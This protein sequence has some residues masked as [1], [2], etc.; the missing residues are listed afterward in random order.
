MAEEPT[1]RRSGCRATS[2]RKGGSHEYSTRETVQP[3]EVPGGVDTRRDRRAPW[4]APQFIAETLLAGEGFTEVHYIELPRSKLR[5]I[6]TPQTL[7]LKTS[8]Q[9][10]AKQASG[11]QT[12]RD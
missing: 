11:N 6:K 8:G 5:G 2:I 10:Q 1:G 3:A 12:P 7:N 4:R 9:F